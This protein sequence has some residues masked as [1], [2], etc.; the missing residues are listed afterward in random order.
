MAEKIYHDL[1]SWLTE[2]QMPNGKRKVLLAAVELFSK[3]GFDGVSTAQIAELS[4]MSEATVFKYF[5]TKHN[6]LDQ[7]LDPVITNLIPNYANDF[8]NNQLPQDVSDDD[9]IKAF[10][11][12]RLTFIVENQ[13][14][15][16]ILVN[17]LL[18]SDEFL[19]KLQTI[20]MPY[21]ESLTVILDQLTHDSE[22]AAI[23]LFRLLVGQ[24]AF[25]LFRMTRFDVQEQYDLDGVSKIISDTVIKALA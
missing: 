9:L 25:E 18:V 14:I 5:K 24:F 7:I 19:H 1:A 6:L 12:N 22:I 2:E 10:V 16:Q 11:K 21:F 15:L 17:E 20:I 3:H 4:G 8:V 23:D 13:D